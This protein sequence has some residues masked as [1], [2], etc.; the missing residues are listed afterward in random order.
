[1]SFHLWVAHCILDENEINGHM[2]K[3]VHMWFVISNN[4]LQAKSIFILI[5]SVALSILNLSNGKALVKI[6]AT[7]SAVLQ[8]SSITVFYFTWS[9]K[10]WYLI[11]IY[12]FLQYCTRILASSMANLLSTYMIVPSSCGLLNS[13]RRLF[14]LIYSQIVD[15]ITTYL[16]S[17]VNNATTLCFFDIHVKVV[18]SR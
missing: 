1:M 10:K 6:S 15:V 7:C 13:F 17:H 14:N 18:D 5:P 11:L 4:P 2:G 12:L 3:R 16:A 9:L 8:Y